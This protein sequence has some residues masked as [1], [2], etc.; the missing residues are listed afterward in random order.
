[1][2]RLI[3]AIALAV[4]S[5]LPGHGQTVPPPAPPIGIVTTVI[6]TATVRSLGVPGEGYL[7]ERDTLREGQIVRTLMGSRL[8][9][10]LMDGSTL[11]LG[12]ATELRLDHLARERGGAS[13]FSVFTLF[14]G[15]LRTV[16]A[17]LR[18]ESAFEVQTPSMVAAVRGTEWVQRHRNLRTELLVERGSVFVAES[19]SDLPGQ[20]RPPPPLVMEPGEGVGWGPLGVLEPITRWVA[21]RVEQFLTATFLPDPPR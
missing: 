15:Y 16:V 3:V 14:E 19:A 12:E 11:S 2:R 4:L 13:R 7:S 20:S 21:P 6:G 9:V 10:R 1:M 17:P 18:S 8:R 5:P